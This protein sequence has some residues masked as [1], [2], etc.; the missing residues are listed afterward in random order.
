[1]RAPPHADLRRA[2]PAR[3]SRARGAAPAQTLA[4]V[5]LTLASDRS[6]ARSRPI[7][8]RNRAR[9]DSSACLAR[10]ARCDERFPRHVSR[11]RFA[12]RTRKREQHRTRRERDHRCLRPGRHDGTRPRR[13]PPTPAALR[14][15]RAEGGA[16]RHARSGA[17]RACSAR[18]M[19]FRPP[20]SAPG[21][22]PRARHARLERAQRAPSSSGA[23]ASRSPQRPARRRPV[24]AGGNGA[25]SSSPSARS[26]SSR[27]PIS[28]RRRTSR[29]RACAALT[30]V[31][32]R[33]ERRPR[34][35]ERLRGQP[36][37]RETSAISA[38]ATT[39]LARATASLGP[40]ARAALS[41]RE[42]SRERDRRA[43]PSRCLEARAQ[44]RRHAGRPASMR[45]GGS[46]AA[47][48]R[49]A[50]VISES[51]GIPSH[52]SLPPFDVSAAR[53]SHDQQRAI[54]SERY[55]VPARRH[56]RSL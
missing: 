39:H 52:L 46:P 38:S 50:A 6:S 41:Q 29:C 28:S 20:P 45:R 42:P 19:R 36:R 49:A 56:E 27:R 4:V 11:P 8:T 2:A 7:S 1:M 35:V 48:A 16:P 25:G 30:R 13:A 26:A 10:N 54:G 43:A 51:I 55:R 37:S 31:A 15:P 12:E 17:P 33:F 5:A 47:S 22:L 34:R 18:G 24:D 3:R 53:L 14:P 9:C 23:V 44:A 21:Y 32:V 40:K